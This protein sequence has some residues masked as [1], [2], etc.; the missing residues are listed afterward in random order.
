MLVRRV[1]VEG[2]DVAGFLARHPETQVVSSAV[3]AGEKHVLHCVGQALKAFAQGRNVS[4]R[5]ELEFLLCL[6]GERQ[7]GKAL[8]KAR[9]GKDVVFVCWAPEAEEVFAGFLG[10]F[11]GVEK[12]LLEASGDELK[13]ALERG[14]VYW[15]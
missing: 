13:A 12:R 14:A 7:I 1:L 11:G 15:L 5:A 6:T 2:G 4:S 3:V 8:E 10:E 9:P